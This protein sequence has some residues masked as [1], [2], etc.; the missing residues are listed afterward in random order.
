MLSNH[1][2]TKSIFPN[3]ILTLVALCFFQ[4]AVSVSAQT[5][6]E[7]SVIG[8]TNMVG[9]AHGETIRFKAFNPSETDS[10]RANEPLGMQLRIYDEHGSLIAES[11]RVDIPPGEFRWVDI[12]RDDLPVA[13]EPGTGRAQVRTIPLW[14]LRTSARIHV[15]TQLEIVD[16]TT[17]AGTFKFFFNV[18]ALP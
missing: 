2:R 8:Q 11:P 3:A 15:P 14:G 16:S 12:K 6:G 17:G 4:L 9:V 18:E 13:G 5:S 7:K 1:G 10:G